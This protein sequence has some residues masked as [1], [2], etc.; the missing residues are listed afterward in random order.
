MKMKQNIWMSLFIILI[1]G[2]CNKKNDYREKYIG[3]FNFTV[4]CYEWH[5]GA[6][7]NIVNRPTVTYAGTISIYNWGDYLKDLN[8]SSSYDEYIDPYQRITIEFSENNFVTPALSE[9]GTLA[10]ESIPHYNCKGQFIN[11]DEIDFIVE[12][13]GS[14]GLTLN[15]HVT[16]TRK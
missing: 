2:G 8:Y 11:N 1:I 12:D 13:I 10:E 15:Y 9:G 4:E 3:N 16:G 7:I 14:A 6:R 5:T